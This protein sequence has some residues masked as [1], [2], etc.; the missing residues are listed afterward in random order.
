M[1]KVIIFALLALVFRISFPLLAPADTGAA[2]ST[3]SFSVPVAT[4]VNCASASVTAPAGTQTNT[5][6]V[7]CT[8]T[9]NPNNL[10]SGTTN[11]FSPAT[12]TMTSGS[13]TLTA[14]RQP[15][16]ISPDASVTAITGTSAGFSG[17]LGSSVTFSST[18]K[19][20]TTYTVLT[21]ATTRAGTYTSG[22]IAYTWST[23]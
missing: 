10:A 15:T 18:W 2:T 19:V 20:Q 3:M 6:T 13:N 16:V 9:G 8:I 22:T 1:K 12:S 23:I 11:A 14:T 7:L 17:L 21:T 5:L 4:S